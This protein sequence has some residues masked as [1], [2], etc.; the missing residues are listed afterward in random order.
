M[1]VLH[2]TI[3][4]STPTCC[5][6]PIFPLRAIT[7]FLWVLQN[8]LKGMS[9][10]SV[11]DSSSFFTRALS[12]QMCTSFHYFTE[13]ALIKT[14]NDLPIVKSNGQL[15]ILTWVHLS[16]FGF[17][18]TT[19]TEFLSALLVVSSQSYLLVFLSP[20]SLYIE[21][22]GVYVLDPLFFSIYSYFLGDFLKTRDFKYHF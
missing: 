3:S 11:S 7:S 10:P 21:I 4:S 15:S 6:S 8:V 19:L 22:P 5:S 12:N 18:D 17:W 1:L 13:T 20:R 14:M 9:R 2:W 16:S